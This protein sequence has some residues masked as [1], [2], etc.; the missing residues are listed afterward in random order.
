VTQVRF[1]QAAR[2]VILDPDDHALLV[3]FV[4]PSGIEAW[5]LPGGGLDPGETVEAGLRRELAEELGL[6]EFEIG[7]HIWN[8]EHV[9]PM[10]TGHDGQRDTIH[11]V[12]V[13]H[14]DPVP[15]IGW[16]RMRAEF[17]H[18]MRWW[19]PA[20]IAAAH[21]R[22]FAPARLAR[23]L[24]ELLASGPPCVPIDTGI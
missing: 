5:A 14:F 8:R 7:P 11:L 23:L 10:I 9:I 3:R 13:E 21:D 22:R 16:D 1:R 19:S 12:R 17:V 2:A 6:V 18:E 24:D 4:F 20:E 15:Q